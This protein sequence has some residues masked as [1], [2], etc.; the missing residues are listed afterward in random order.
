MIRSGVRRRASSMRMPPALL[1]QLLRDGRVQ[2]HG[3]IGLWEARRNGDDI[4]LLEGGVRIATLHTLRQQGRKTRGRPNR[5]LADYVAHDTPDY[6]G[7]FA[8]GIRTGSL[9]EDY[10]RDH[11]DYNAI[12]VSALADRLAEAFA[13]RL[14]ERVR[15]EFWG[16]VPSESLANTDLIHERYQGIRPAPGYP[17][18]PDHTEKRTLWKLMN[19]EKTTGIR[20][21]DSLAMYPAASVC[22]LYLA[23]PEAA[24]FNVG[25]I[26][27]DQ[28]ADYAARK[29][30]TPQEVEYW[31]SSRLNY[32]PDTMQ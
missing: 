13:E 3:V 32:E 8:V 30:L 6:I 31:L 2:A 10:R 7:A 17:A 26:G 28:V 23:H 16:Y 4:A 22:G 1:D 5:A 27:R 19:V 12:M 11:D 20:L 18:C 21:T 29:G 9:A 15:K 25:L 14:H 24:Y